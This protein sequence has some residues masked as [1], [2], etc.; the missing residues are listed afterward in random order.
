MD[1]SI[2]ECDDQILD[3]ITDY[4]SKKGLFSKPFIW[5]SVKICWEYV[6]RL[7]QIYQIL[8]VKFYCFR[9]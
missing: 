4:N 6:V 2:K 1:P 8:L 9:Q 7:L 5:A 3:E